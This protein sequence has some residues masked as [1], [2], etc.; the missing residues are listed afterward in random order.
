MQIYLPTKF[1]I[2]FLLFILRQQYNDHTV[3]FIYLF[4][5]TI[6]C[7]P[8]ETKILSF[9][10]SKLQFILLC[11][12]L[13]DVLW[14]HFST[15]QNIPSTIRNRYVF[16]ILLVSVKIKIRDFP[17]KKK[18]QK[19]FYT[20]FKHVVF[21]NTHIMSP[22]IITITIL[23]SILHEVSPGSIKLKVYYKYKNFFYSIS[24]TI[25]LNIQQNYLNPTR[26]F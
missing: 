26:N 16:T 12:I 4:Q 17:T 18:E 2:T 14:Y 1:A 20:C 24:D 11:H 15:Y 5:H 19:Y 10:I 8:E 13:K 23:I 22:K 3:Y 25:Y 6:T 21:N 9:K 7:Q